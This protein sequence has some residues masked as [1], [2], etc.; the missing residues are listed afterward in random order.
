ML[1]HPGCGAAVHHERMK[2]EY[3]L[4]ERLVMASALTIRTGASACQRAAASG[5]STLQVAE[6]AS[7]VLRATLRD[8]ESPWRP[9][10]PGGP[11]SGVEHRSARR[12]SVATRPN[13]TYMTKVVDA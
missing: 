2:N 10:T 13:A 4:T 9:V 11:V 5:G 8:C 3:R 7:G 1:N 12:N 6:L